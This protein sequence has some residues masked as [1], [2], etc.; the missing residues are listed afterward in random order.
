MLGVFETGLSQ[1]GTAQHASDLLDPFNIIHPPHIRLGASPFLSLLDKKVLIA[2]CS[3]L[4]Q[5][6][7]AQHLLALRE[8]LQLAPDRLCRPSPDANIDLVKYERARQR[9]LLLAAR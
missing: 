8:H 3:D 9:N 7:N 6:R 5:M 4:R 1:C 2:K